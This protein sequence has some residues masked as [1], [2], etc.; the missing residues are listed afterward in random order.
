MAFVDLLTDVYPA[1]QLWGLIEWNIKEPTVLSNTDVLD[2]LNTELQKVEGRNLDSTEISQFQ[3]I[4]QAVQDNKS[5][6]NTGYTALEGEQVQTLLE[7][8]WI[9]V[10]TAK[11]LLGIV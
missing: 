8:E 3:N 1:H 10:Q 5:D 9:D 2:I 6:P 11:Q 7:A 4:K